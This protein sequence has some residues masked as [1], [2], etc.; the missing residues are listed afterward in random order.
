[1]RVFDHLNRPPAARVKPD[2]SN[3]Q[4]EELATVWIGHATVLLLRH[5]R[6]DDHHRSGSC[7]T[8]WDWDWD[9]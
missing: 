1:M 7:R 9:W 8:A 5:W 6:D 4:N 3:W 2:L